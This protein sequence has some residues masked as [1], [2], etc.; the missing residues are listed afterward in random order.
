M[1]PTTTS[2]RFVPVEPGIVIRGDRKYELDAEGRVRNDGGVVIG[3]LAGIDVQDIVAPTAQ[4][5]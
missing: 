3:H 4:P 1:T 5:A 2:F